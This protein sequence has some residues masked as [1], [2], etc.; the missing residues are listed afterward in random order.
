MGRLYPPHFEV[1]PARLSPLTEEQRRFA[2]ENH[3]LIYAFLGRNGCNANDYYDAAALG[4]LQAVQR[5]LTQPR[6]R[7]YAFATIAWQA[8]GREVA[9]DCRAEARQKEAE[10]RYA[11]LSQPRP[12]DIHEA[13][14]SRLILHETLAQATP[15]QRQLIRLRADG[16][17]VSEAARL[18][19]IQVKQAGRLLK[20]LRAACAHLYIK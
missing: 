8:M 2:E 9:R 5:Y 6:L 11:A 15:G 1:R 19:G 3:G 12:P 17:S 20:E 14:E 7:R 10:R 16:Y 18:Q 4:F 13:A